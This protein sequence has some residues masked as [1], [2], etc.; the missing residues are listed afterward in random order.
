MTVALTSQEAR[1][2]V[3]SEASTSGLFFSVTFVKKD[4][5]TRRMGCRGRV[6]TKRAGGEKA[7]EPRPQGMVFVWDLQK[8][9]YRTVNART[10]RSIV[11]KGK[12]YLVSDQP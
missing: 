8:G 9:A 3:L 12:T 1:D 7:W 5:S 10:I 6:W 11:H 2:L 4:G